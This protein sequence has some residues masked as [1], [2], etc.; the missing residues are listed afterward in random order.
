MVVSGVSLKIW[1]LFERFKAHC[2]EKGWTVCGTEDLIKVG[3][4]YHYLLWSRHTRPLTFRRTVT[5]DRKIP[6]PEGNTSKLVN[7]S[8]ILWVSLD[9]INQEALTIFAENPALFQKVAVYDLSPIKNNNDVCFKI[10]KTDSEVFRA[11]EQFLSEKYC[12]TFKHFD[13]I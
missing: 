9:P 12:V 10:N 4:D 8:Y 7:V 3:T 1:D 6:I 5:G 13:K 11:F 2:D